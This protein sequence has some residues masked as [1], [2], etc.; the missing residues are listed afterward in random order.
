MET[1]FVKKQVLFVDDADFVLDSL[2]RMLWTQREHWEPTFVNT[3][4]KAWARLLEQDFDA[5][6]SDVKMP[7]T[8]GLQL[9]QRMRTTAR[10]KDIPVVMLTGLS[11]RKLKRRALDCGAT[12]LLS[13]PVEPEDLLARLRSVLQLK[14]CQDALRN[15]NELL[16]RRIEERTEAL[17]Y[18]RLEI[19]WRLGK[20]AEQRDEKTGHHVIRVGCAAQVVAEALGMDRRFVETLFL[21][22]PLHD[23]GK[24]GIPHAILRRRG[25]QSPAHRA[26]MRQH[27]LIGARILRQDRRVRTAFLQ[28]RGRGPRPGE[29][30]FRDPFLEMAASIALTHHEHWDGRGYPQGLAREKIPLESRIVTICDVYDCVTSRRP[31]RERYPEDKALNVIRSAAGRHFDPGVHAAFIKSLPQ[32]RSIEERFADDEQ[33]VPERGEKPDVFG[34]ASCVHP[35]GAE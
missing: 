23:I 21:A 32:I 26:V 20:V 11:D 27:C 13:K 29:D 15:H 34:P 7:G 25:P 31:Y 4:E 9:L 16:E 5:V 19:V 8:D 10:T 33:V 17:A 12:D 35:A 1:P 14:S 18:S 3:A 30:G 2:G 28:W 6:V 24:I 22:A